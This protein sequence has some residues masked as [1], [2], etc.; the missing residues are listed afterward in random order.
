MSHSEPR[1]AVGWPSTVLAALCCVASGPVVASNQD[2]FEMSLEELV[3]LSVT[4]V[5][6]KAERLSDTTSA[7]FVI[8]SEDIQRQG[9]RSVPDALRL[10]PGLSVLQ[11][12]A[13]KW[14]IG[15]RGEAGR[16]ANKLLVLMD[17]RILYTPS[18]S[19]VFWDVQSTLIEE[20]ERIE[21]IR[22]PGAAVWGSNASNGVINIITKR[23]DPGAG[24]SFIAGMDP[25]GGSFAALQHS[26]ALPG[27]GAYRSFAKYHSADANRL[28]GGGEANDEWDLWRAGV[29]A[30]RESG[31][32]SWSASLEG[33][34]GTMGETDIRFAPLPPFFTAAPTDADVE[35][36]FVTLQWSRQHEGDAQ[37]AVDVVVDYTDR[38]AT[39]YSERRTTLS[40]DLRHQWSLARHEFI[41]GGQVRSNNYDFADSA[42][43]FFDDGFDNINEDLVVA[44]FLQDEITL[45]EDAV[46]LTL[47]AKL[48][49]NEFSPR[50]VEFM[51]TARL[52]WKPSAQHSVWAGAARGVRT[53][54]IAD[55]GLRS[56][57]ILPARP[58]GQANP[59]PVPLRTGSVPNADFE[60]EVLSAYEAGVRGRL[61]DTIGYDLSAYIFDYD[62]LR[63]FSPVDTRCLPADVSVFTDPLCVLGA[64]SVLSDVV[65]VNDTSTRTRGAE[66]V[67]DWL[68]ANDLRVVGHVSWANR[69]L[70]DSPLGTATPFQYPEWQASLRSEY[71]FGQRFSVAGVVRY[72]DEID[73][74]NF[75]E[76]YWQGNLNLRWQF[77][78]DWVLYAGVRNLFRDS[79]LEY[80]SE[81]FE[82]LPT[83]IERA[84]YLNVRY[85]F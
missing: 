53:P 47:G 21:V 46:F 15:A 18:F 60:S 38:D 17:G 10:A 33:Y 64:Q 79:T 69:D 82:G 56:I 49:R 51:P 16:F 25:E 26:G 20:I 35:G 68:P 42:R 70:D 59:F 71:Q 4:S 62:N 41:V 39:L 1:L 5:S 31:D 23:P 8:T 40:L 6:R 67:V 74:P 9:I 57:D 52:L 77:D 28:V 54:S 22:G 11:I 30:V 72:V 45:R 24:Q 27:G 44:A 13:N 84:A 7:V 63:T 66:L 14:A 19:G 12:D 32:D 43:L 58:P 83:E 37:T 34:M 85:D 78:D 48:E 76:D 2:L 36:A 29:R 3:N 75:V 50:S 55:K 81:L 65:F 80:T 61:T 73:V